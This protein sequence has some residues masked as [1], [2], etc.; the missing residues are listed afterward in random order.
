M[1]SQLGATLGIRWVEARNVA[2]T[3]QRTE[4]QTSTPKNR[5]VP[6]AVMR[7][8]RTSSEQRGRLSNEEAGPEPEL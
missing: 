6:N 7:R 3:G 4:E 8:L 1:L 2:N 5:L